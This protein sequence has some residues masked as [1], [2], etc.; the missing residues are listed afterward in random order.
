MPHDDERA[1]YTVSEAGRRLGIGRNS[2]YEAARRKEIPTI[3]VGRRI[4]V[5][6][7][8]LDRLLHGQSM[9]DLPWE[10]SP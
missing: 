6:R 7:T 3:K 10:G 2:A 1:T 8:Q 4:L 9:N 5:P